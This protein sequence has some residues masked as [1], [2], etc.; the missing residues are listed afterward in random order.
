MNIVKTLTIAAAL[1]MSGS[2]VTAQDMIQKNNVT[3]K[4]DVMT[5]EALWAMGRIGGYSASPSGKQIV[6][7]V[8][9]YSVEKNKSHQMLY[10]MN[11]DGSGI[12]ALTTDA[13]SETDASWIANGRKIA[14]LREGE[15]WTMDANGEN[16]KKLSD[17]E[18]AI[19]GYKFS[20]DSKKVILLKSLDYHGTIKKNP[21]D[22]PL[23]TGRLVTDMNYRHWDHYVEQISHA[24]VADVTENG[25]ANVVDILEGEPYECPLAPFGGIEQLDWSIDSKL[26]AY[27]CRKKEGVDYAISTDAD[28]YI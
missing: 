15:I 1:T 2:F 26:V 3:L 9:Y 20:P 24:F 16:R 6:Y 5:P 4:S 11:V 21:S 22:L 8:G 25:I 27:T 18:G 23:A 17:T 12:K 13:K 10:I 19:E 7:Q 14:F 28:I